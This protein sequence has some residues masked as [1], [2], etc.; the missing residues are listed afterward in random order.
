MTETT[1]PAA[2]YRALLTRP[3]AALVAGALLLELAAALGVYVVQVV[4]PQVVADLEATQTYPLILSGSAVGLFLALPLARPA[5]RRLGPA[6]VLGF[7]LGIEVV[8]SLLTAGAPDALV[9]AAGRLAT[10]FGGGLLGVFGVSA[11]IEHLPTALRARLIA[12]ISSMWILP[13]LVGPAA[14]LALDHAVGWRWTLLAPV[15]V[16]LVARV[17]VGPAAL[18]VRPTG[19]DPFRATVLLLPAGLAVFVFGAGMAWGYLGLPLALVGGWAALPRGTFRAAPGVTGHLAVLGMV[20]IGFFGLDGVFTTVA[21]RAAGVSLNWAA[22]AL[23]LAAFA[24]AMLSLVQPRLAGRD[25]ARAGRWI[26][27]GLGLQLIALAVVAGVTS[28]DVATGPAYLLCWVV[29]GAGMGLLYPAVYLGA[30]TRQDDRP[31]LDSAV[32]A[33]A[34]ILTEAFGAQ[35]GTALGGGV[36][37]AAQLLEFSEAD[38][39]RAATVG[40]AVVAGLTFLLGR[41]VTR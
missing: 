9:F 23:G 40:F 16:A 4:T 7:A 39:L 26:R 13:G 6:P 35:L 12:L 11:A 17:L 15:P 33:S 34:V 2:G 20:S 31:E 19:G 27:I 1:A 3:Y 14:V 21:T 10:A 18:R 30:T 24:W 32:L 28:A 37:Q 29:G 38:G 5:M 25:G 8:G 22:V 41:R 36:V